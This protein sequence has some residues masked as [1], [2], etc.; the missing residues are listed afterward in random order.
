MGY[1]SVF[2]TELFKDQT[3]I[4]TGGGSGMGRSTS[5][6]HLGGGSSGGGGSGVTGGGGSSGIS[7]GVGA[8]ACGRLVTTPLTERCLHS[9]LSALHHTN[10]A[11]P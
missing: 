10:S 8:M 11:S 1:H 3:I 4:V 9:M 6:A 7:R 2:R 5:R